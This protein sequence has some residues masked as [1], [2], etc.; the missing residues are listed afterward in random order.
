MKIIIG[1]RGKMGQ[2]LKSM[3]EAQGI[4]VLALVDAMHLE[5]MAG[6]EEADMVVDFSHADNLT[7]ILPYCL[8]HA[9]PLVYGTTGLS[10][11]DIA[12][13][14][15]LSK[16]VPVFYSANY[17]YGVAVLA[18]LVKEAAALLKGSFDM[19]LVEIHHRQ[20]QDAPSGTAKML[21]SMMD[22]SGTAPFTFG[23]EGN[24][25]P[26]PEG[27]IGVHS[28]RGGTEAGEHMVQFFGDDET[29]TIAHRALDRKIF[30]SG[31]LRAARFLLGKKA[32]MYTMEDLLAANEE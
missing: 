12:N 9:C 29:I 13:L 1:G 4:E 11:A 18:R 15:G 30:A 6:L 24:I 31:A 14:K 3:A 32:G 8:D 10:E 19:E 7:W 25:G 2:L 28:L 22:P 5:E 23:R 16:E 17:S 20:K 26:R 27:E 21:L